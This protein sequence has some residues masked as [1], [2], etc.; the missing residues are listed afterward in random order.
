MWFENTGSLNPPQKTCN[1]RKMIAWVCYASTDGTRTWRR[2]DLDLFSH[3]HETVPP[4]FLSEP[5]PSSISTMYR[6]YSCSEITNLTSKCW[7][8]N[9]PH[10]LFPFCSDACR[11]RRGKRERAFRV[12]LVDWQ[13]AVRLQRQQQPPGFASYNKISVGLLLIIIV[14]YR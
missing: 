5:L 8:L 6:C 3:T 11:R 9:L 2:I 4:R 7:T 12:W 1:S 13:P 10:C 14:H